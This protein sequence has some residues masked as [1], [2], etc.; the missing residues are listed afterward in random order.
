M[1]TE[2][3]APALLLGLCAALT[4]CGP[5]ATTT[6]APPA[7]P[8]NKAGAPAATPA[9]APAGQTAEDAAMQKEIQEALKKKGVEDVTVEVK[10]KTV[11]L[12]GKMRS[13]DQQKEITKTAEDIAFPKMYSVR[14]NF[15][16]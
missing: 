3:T 5:P 9:P 8:A 15:S 13:A 1:R 12:K 10:N 16:T 6:N 14:S 2:L 11:D 7:A 4:A